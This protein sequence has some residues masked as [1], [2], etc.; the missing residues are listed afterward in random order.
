MALVQLLVL[1]GWA[2]PAGVRDSHSVASAGRGTGAGEARRRL[3]VFHIGPRNVSSA[4]IP[5]SMNSGSVR[6]EMYWDLGWKQEAVECA[7]SSAAPHLYAADCLRSGDNFLESQNISNLVIT[8][9]ELEI[10]GRFDQF[11]SCVPDEFGRNY[12]CSPN[13]TA[14]GTWN[15]TEI[16]PLSVYG[17]CSSP[18]DPCRRDNLTR[19]DFWRFNTWQKIGGQWYST[20]ARG[21]CE[22][23]QSVGHA[24]CTWK[25]SRLVKQVAKECSDRGVFSAVV[26]RNDDCFGRCPTPQNTSSAC[27]IKCF[28]ETMVGPRAGDGIGP[29]YIRG[30]MSLDELERAWT[31]PFRTS[32]ASAGGCPNLLDPSQS[33][34]A[35]SIDTDVGK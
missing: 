5:A 7:N 15:L 8:Q 11:A 28:Y 22:A 25:V 19:L 10:D 14:V 9:V 2:A 18:T 30:G 17:N 24:G 21:R 13:T 32:D 35:S 1:G 33:T 3:V 23:G 34:S 16:T 31:A 6:G 29:E 27:F 20:P 12:R 26:R 4:S